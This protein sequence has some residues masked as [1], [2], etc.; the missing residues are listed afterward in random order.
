M[1][2]EELRILKIRIG[3]NKTRRPEYAPSHFY[4]IINSSDNALKEMTHII[5]E[6]PGPMWGKIENP[7]P[8]FTERIMNE[9]GQKT[10][11]MWPHFEMELQYFAFNN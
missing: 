5:F 4:I 6:A 8:T 3:R 11:K 7:E 1:I 10:R 2:Q 9:N